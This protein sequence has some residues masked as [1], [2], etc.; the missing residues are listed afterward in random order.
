LLGTLKSR[1]NFVKALISEGLF[2]E[3]LGSLW[4]I[5]GMLAFFRDEL[6]IPN[7][8]KW[9]FVNLVVQVSGYTWL[10]VGLGLL[11]IWIIESSFHVINRMRLHNIELSKIDSADL[12]RMLGGR[13]CFHRFIFDNDGYLSG[14]FTGSM[15][16]VELQDKFMEMKVQAPKQSIA[17]I[18]LSFMNKRSEQGIIRFFFRDKNGNPQL[19]ENIY[20]EINVPVNDQGKFA[21][22]F[23]CSHG[24]KLYENA[25]LD[26]WAK[27]W[28]K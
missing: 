15:K 24:Y 22:Q 20:D 12:E 2:V 4:G 1:W 9:K 7:L 16:L 18:R 13:F 10:L 5:W 25:S 8:D 23:I 3:F 21:L 17:H 27:G 6:G 28:T 26:V 14:R 11:V 19:I